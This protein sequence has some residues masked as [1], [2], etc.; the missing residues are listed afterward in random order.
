LSL[1]WQEA[2]LKD[3]ANKRKEI[4]GTPML[5]RRLKEQLGLLPLL[6]P[7]IASKLD[8]RKSGVTPWDRLA[9]RLAVAHLL[10]WESW[11]HRAAHEHRRVSEQLEKQREALAAFGS[12]VGELR[13]YES[14][15]HEELKKIALADDSRPFRIGVRAIR[16]WDR[17]RQSWLG[18]AGSSMVAR[19]ESLAELQKKLSGRFGD[20]DVF[21]W[22]AAEGREHLWKERDPL[23]DLARF[24]AIDRLLQRKKSCAQH[25]APDPVFHPRWCLYEAA[26]GSNL[27]TYDIRINDGEVMLDLPLL[28]ADGVRLKEKE[29]S[30][31][32][33]PSGQMESPRWNGATKKARRLVFRSAH[34]EFSADLG[35]GEILF[36]RRYIENRKPEALREGEI[37]PVWFK[38]V[39]QLDSQAPPDW[40]DGRLAV[41]NGRC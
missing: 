9:M 12:L 26:D 29:F 37:G 6:S 21:R 8:E 15:R 28:T 33:A 3:Q 41:A 1:P 16:A 10:S 2:F 31:G 24:N 25:T 39:M 4:G 7:P 23:P 11:N 27:R 32:L 13:Q 30:V 35:G 18:T 17:V 36:Q 14:D 5:I 19:M 38:L 22:L 40:L 20:P 34:Q